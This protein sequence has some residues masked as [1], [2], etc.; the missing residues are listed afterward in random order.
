MSPPFAI[1]P[2]TAADR[3]AL[4]R[5]GAV[6]VGVHHALD[7]LRF[8]P[9]TPGTEH[10]YGGFLVGQLDEPDVFV[11]V[12][13]LGGTVCGYAYAGVEGNDWM[14]LRGPAGALYDV[15]VDP[16]HRHEGIGRALLEA[17]LAELR[18]RGATRVVLMTAEGN[19]AA[20]RL[21]AA[22]GFRRTMIEMTLELASR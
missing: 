22:A 6:M 10:G 17:A 9:V 3:A 14:V 13:V 19:S 12:A 5:L 15:V 20:H 7:P 11:L 8:I 1:R 16:A 21:F 18:R 2:A 4:G